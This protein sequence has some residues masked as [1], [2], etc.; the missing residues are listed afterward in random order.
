MAYEVKQRPESATDDSGTLS[1]ARTFSI[2][3]TVIDS[4]GQRHNFRKF[5][6]LGKWGI[7]DAYKTKIIVRA[8]HDYLYVEVL[9]F[10]QVIVAGDRHTGWDVYSLTGELLQHYSKMSLSRLKRILDSKKRNSQ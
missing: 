6:W 3:I 1:M 10:A 9:L 7:C 8:K 5:E 4:N 2:P